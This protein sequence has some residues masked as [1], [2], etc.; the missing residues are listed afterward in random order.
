MKHPAPIFLFIVPLGL[1]VIVLAVCV[2]LFYDHFGALFFGPK[3]GNLRIMAYIGIVFFPVLTGLIMG[4]I[5]SI[6]AR[7]EDRKYENLLQNAGESQR[8]LYQDFST[9]LESI[10]TSIQKLQR[11]SEI[12]KT[13]TEKIKALE[14]QI[15]RQPGTQELTT[16]KTETRSVTL[17]DTVIRDLRVIHAADE[18]IL[19]ELFSVHR[20]HQRPWFFPRK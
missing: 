3:T 15:R 12:L 19:Q 1:L 20:S 16:E 7:W 2:I 6:L 18:P 5:I 10:E 8:I 14:R 4:L 11:C 13:Q 9:G 17:E